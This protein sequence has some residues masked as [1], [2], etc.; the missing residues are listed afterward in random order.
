[1]PPPT[2]ASSRT[3]SCAGGRLESIWVLRS[4]SLRTRGWRN[5]PDSPQIAR[6]AHLIIRLRPM[7]PFSLR[8]AGVC[9]RNRE[10]MERGKKRGE[11]S[12]RAAE[13]SK[14]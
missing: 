9:G 8:G 11:A 7:G 5:P 6:K 3:S 4:R 14:R 12:F 1:M 10:G 13:G 2:Y